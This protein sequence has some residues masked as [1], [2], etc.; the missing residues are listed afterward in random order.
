MAGVVF[1]FEENDVD[2]YSGRRIDLDAWNYAIKLAGDVDTMIVINRTNQELTTPDAH[3]NFQVV[4]QMPE[5]TGEIAHLIC[6]WDLSTHKTALWDFNHQVDWYVF[7]P[8][9]GWTDK[10]P[11]SGIYMPQHGLAACHSVHVATAVMAHRY[12][13]VQWQ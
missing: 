2:V 8:G 12:K 9:T 11:E 10:A 5:L 3:L 13:V 4:S 7:G 1:Y 6:P